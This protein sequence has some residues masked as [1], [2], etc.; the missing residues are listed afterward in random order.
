MEF[1]GIGLVA[2]IIGLNEIIKK[3]GI[4]PKFIPVFSLA[5]GLGAGVLVG[6]NIE[7]VIVLG[8]AMGLS[9]CGLYSS[10]KNVAQGIK[11]E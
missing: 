10:V 2:V 1:A 4:N 3:L 11:G 7:E 9:A 6:T 8:L 5:F